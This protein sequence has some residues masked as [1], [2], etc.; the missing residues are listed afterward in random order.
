MSSGWVKYTF[1]YLN[2][3]HNIFTKEDWIKYINN[4]SRVFLKPKNYKF[5]EKIV[6]NYTNIYISFPSPSDADI[7]YNKPYIKLLQMIYGEKNP[8]PAFDYKKLLNDLIDHVSLNGKIVFLNDPYQMQKIY[9]LMFHNN[10][11]DYR[12][13]M[14]RYQWEKVKLVNQD[15]KILR[16][17]Y[18]V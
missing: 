12:K 1:C 9:G 4:I 15:Y 16:N 3:K 11:F 6:K 2:K 14:N 17:P 5:I 10:G 8:I 18:S 13:F 7:Y